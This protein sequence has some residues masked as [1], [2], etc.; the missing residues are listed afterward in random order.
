MKLSLFALLA[1]AVPIF[2]ADTSYLAKMIA[3]EPKEEFLV[4]QTYDAFLALISGHEV[5]KE[6]LRFPARLAIRNDRGVIF[7]R[8]FYV[9]P[10]EL[11]GFELFVPKDCVTEKD[12]VLVSAFA[13][14]VDHEETKQGIRRLVLRKVPNQSPGPTPSAAH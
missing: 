3:C 8:A 13:L 1:L 7:S 5:K 12:G 11:R 10:N 9:S 2:A 4:T 6:E 14:A